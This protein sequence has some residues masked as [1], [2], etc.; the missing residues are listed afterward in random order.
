MLKILIAVIFVVCLTACAEQTPEP[1]TAPEEAVSEDTDL[2]AKASE[3]TEDMQVRADD[4]GPRDQMP[5]ARLF[6]E[7][8]ASCHNGSVPKAPHLHW[9]E[10]MSPGNVLAAMNEGIMVVQAQGLS[11]RER[12]DIA[13]YVTMKSARVSQTE[14]TPVACEGPAAEFDFKRQPAQVGWGHDTARYAGADIAG[15]TADDVPKLKLKWAFA[16]PGALRARSQ[17]AVGM[18]A[19]FTGSQDGNVYAFDLETGCVRWTFNAGAEVRTGIVL[20]P[21]DQG[22]TPLAIFGNIV[23]T[24]FAVNASTGE[25]VWSAKIDDHPSATLTGTPALNGNQL[26]VPV[27]S[28]EVIPAANPQYECCTF[29][30]KVVAVN[31]ADGSEIWTHYTIPTPP[32]ETGLT[33]AGTRVFAPS[34]A[35]TWTS[36]AVDRKRNV[37]YVGTGENYSSP[38]DENSDAILA[39]NMT[40]G[41]RVWQRQSTSGDAWNVACMMVDNPNCPAEQGPDF[42]HGSSMILVDLPDG[43]QVLTVGHKNGTIFGLDPDNSGSVLWSTKVGR[44]S[45]QGGVH[46]GMAADGTTLYAPI[47]DMNNTR[48]GDVLDPE[49][50]RPG[51]HALNAANGELLW[52]HVQQNVC[53]AEMEFC[54]PGISAPVSAVDGAVLAGHLD[55][56]VRAYGRDDGSLLWEFDTNQ[57]VA[58]VNGLKAQG[59]GMSGAGPTIVDGHVIINS[60]YGLYFH[61]P[62]NML[63]V[64]S[65][66]GK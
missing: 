19:V 7:H 24:L 35:P 28:L 63:A 49:A 41:E 1:A 56:F 21:G 6:G 43:R 36:P 12:Q 27:S 40:T 26:F 32:V 52:S 65:I 15:L 2:A 60:G 53:P 38:A 11:E 48:N 39:I 13:E 22:R 51:V 44:G 4:F 29:R 59:G 57:P 47:N 58:G 61:S 42:D 31:V 10:M 3:F 14:G 37:I 18:G 8:C 45:I 23:A 16:Y 33:S 34:G 46:F 5:G 9:M 66:D 25:L 17:P 64:F 30:G 54:D 62:G 20:T 55:G 50:A